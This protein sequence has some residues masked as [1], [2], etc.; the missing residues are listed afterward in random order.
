MRNVSDRFVDKIKTHILWSITFFF[1]KIF[2]FLDNVEKHGRLRQTTD[3]DVIWNM[4]CACWIIKATD[5]HS[6]YVLLIIFSRQQ[7][8]RQ[9]ASL[10]YK[11]PLL[12]TLFLLGIAA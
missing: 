6:E 7:W 12:F 4:R 10:L 3:D 9:S 8:S 11:F 5:A 1:S 2:F